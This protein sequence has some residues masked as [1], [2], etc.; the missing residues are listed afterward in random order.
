MYGFTQLAAHSW[1]TFHDFKTYGGTIDDYAILAVTAGSYAFNL[2]CCSACNWTYDDYDCYLGGAYL[3]N[4]GKTMTVIG[5]TKTGD[6]RGENHFYSG[7]STQNIGD[8]YLNWWKLHHGNSH[9]DSVVYW[10]YGMTIL[11][12]PTINFYHDV[13]DY[14]VRDLTLSSFPLGNNSNLILYR[15]AD[16]ITV[17]ADFII[18]VG[19]HVVFDAPVVTISPG[20]LCQLGASFEI[21]SEGCVLYN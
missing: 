13:S 6:M 3:Y 7:L 15:A 9:N 1:V 5:S 4:D 8:S 11:G 19:V 10:S 12:D 17:T 20:F 2:H 21:R 16:S 18:P 14:C